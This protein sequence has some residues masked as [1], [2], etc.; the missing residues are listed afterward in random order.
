MTDEIARSDAVRRWRAAGELGDPDSA[1]DCL[2]LD[3]QLTSPLTGRFGFRGRDQVRV[4]LTAAFAV[5]SEIRFHT[6]LG[7]SD[8]RA[9][10]YRGRIG[11]QELEEAQL[12]RLD[13][14]GLIHEVTLSGRPL[15]ALTGLMSTLGP[16]LTKRQGNPALAAFIGASSKPLHAMTRLGDRRVVPL[17][18]P[19]RAGG[20][21]RRGRGMPQ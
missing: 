19:T 12:L 21:N 10:F 1:A 4:L 14:D 3:V 20:L 9:L 8:T 6:E 16:E 13:A 15:P 11:D 18:A 5:I 7:D 17:A 2:S